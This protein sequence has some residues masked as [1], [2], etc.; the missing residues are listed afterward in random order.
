MVFEWMHGK[1]H[2]KREAVDVAASAV[3]MVCFVVLSLSAVWSDDPPRP[4]AIRICGAVGIVA[5]LTRAVVEIWLWRQRH[6][7][8]SALSSSGRTR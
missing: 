2:S 8:T 4:L 5:L 7:T 6:N 3:M 1:P